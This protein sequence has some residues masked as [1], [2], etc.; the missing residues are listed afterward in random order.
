MKKQS[1]SLVTNR[2]S[3]DVVLQT[4]LRLFKRVILGVLYAPCPTQQSTHVQ[5]E[6]QA[7]AH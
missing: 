7:T 6:N 2:K 3:S 5:D 4:M 1:F